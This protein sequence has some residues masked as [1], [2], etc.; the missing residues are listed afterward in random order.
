MVVVVNHGMVGDDGDDY[1]NDG[2]S[3]S[4]RYDDGYGEMVMVLMTD[5]NDENDDDH[6][7]HHPPAVA[8]AARTQTQ[9]TFKDVY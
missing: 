3:H 4:D 1:N 5:T 7:H 9:K 8:A 2:V 6:H